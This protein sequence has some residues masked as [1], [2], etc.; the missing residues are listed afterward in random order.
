M[1]KLDIALN[2]MTPRQRRA[3]EL[4]LSGLKQRE[5]AIELGVSQPAISKILT[6]G[7]RR[8]KKNL[9]V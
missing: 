2:L 8:A 4:R 3:W 5:I 9:L 7:K 1:E 6:A